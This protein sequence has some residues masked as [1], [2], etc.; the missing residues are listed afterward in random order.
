MTFPTYSSQS[1]MNEMYNK[2]LYSSNT[3]LPSSQTKY[4]RLIF[5]GQSTTDISSKKLYHDGKTT[6]FTI[7]RDESTNFRVSHLSLNPFV[8]ASNIMS[9]AFIRKDSFL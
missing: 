4:N 2:S 1:D 7:F 5:N 3:K 8:G 9:K 6:N